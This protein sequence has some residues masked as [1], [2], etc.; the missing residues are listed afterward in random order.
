MSLLF[1]NFHFPESRV[2]IGVVAVSGKVLT[3]EGLYRKIGLSFMDLQKITRERLSFLKRRQGNIL[4]EKNLEA[5]DITGKNILVIDDG[6]AT[7]F[8]A[9]GAVKDLKKSGAEKVYMAAP[10][11]HKSAKTLLGSD[12]DG[13]TQI[14]E[15][16][17]RVFAVSSYYRMFDAVGD[18]EVREVLKKNRWIFEEE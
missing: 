3:N 12:C 8:T 7:G 2:A 18:K 11:I 5:E 10:V 13:I 15:S 1:Q 17:T 16:E 9:L 6:L 4:S 14:V